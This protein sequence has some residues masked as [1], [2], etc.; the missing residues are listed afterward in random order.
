MKNKDFSV[1]PVGGKYS[2]VSAFHE[3][4]HAIVATHFGQRVSEIDLSTPV[5]TCTHTK[6]DNLDDLAIM[7]LGG[8]AAQVIREWPMLAGIWKDTRERLVRKRLEANTFD[9]NQYSSFASPDNPETFDSHAQKALN[10]IDDNWAKVQAIASYLRT[11]G[12]V[13]SNAEFLSIVEE[14]ESACE[15]VLESGII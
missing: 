6:G 11:A 1:I 4:G 10:I 8:V 12:K 9:L 7:T 2:E 3:S 15:A 5:P 14:S 13:T